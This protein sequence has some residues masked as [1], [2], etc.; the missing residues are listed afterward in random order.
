MKCLITES[1][2]DDLLKNLIKEHGYYFVSKIVGTDYLSEEVFHSNP[3]EFLSLYD[4]LDHFESSEKPGLTI[5]RYEK[6]DN[7]FVVKNSTDD[8]YINYDAIYG[9]LTMFKES[10]IYSV[11]TR[12]LLNWLWNSFGIKSD[13]NHMWTIHPDQDYFSDYLRL[14]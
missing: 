5:Y 6:G 4:G 2:R 14:T 10:Q 13:R 7:I 9:A 12:L 1:Q 3:M 8:V 11:R